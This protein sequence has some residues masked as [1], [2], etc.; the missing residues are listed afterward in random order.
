MS[1]AVKQALVLLLGLSLCAASGCATKETD[2]TL[3]ATY[4]PSRPAQA[5]AHAVAAAPAPPLH[6]DP[7]DSDLL[8]DSDFDTVP[9]NKEIISDPLEP[10][11]RM[12]FTFND[13]IYTN[14]FK[15]VYRAYEFVTPDDLRSGLSNALRNLQAPIR[16]VNSILQ[17]EF[18]QAVVEF[19]RFIVNTTVGGLGLAEIVKPE[20]ALTP[21][22][23]DS[24]N[25]AGTL[26]KW[27]MGEGAYLVW[28]ILGPSTVRDTFGMAGDMLASVPFWATRPVGPMDPML[29]YGVTG[30][31]N[32]NEL[33]DV[34]DNYENITRSAI[35]PYV[36]LRDAYVKLRRS[37]ATPHARIT[38]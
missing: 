4:E 33:G 26:A 14:I 38:R 9:G 28:P 17:L 20:A 34:L 24:A 13:F 5:G 35:E 25:F 27:G 31:L 15:P 11:N 36:S 29:D 32:F 8:D 2:P 37:G 1:A 12:W 7:A 19:G 21:I 16:I 18:A 10:W 22:H 23:L 30:G 3:G 6:A